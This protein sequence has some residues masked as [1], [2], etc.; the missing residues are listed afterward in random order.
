MLEEI[1][2]MRVNGDKEFDNLLNFEA[3]SKAC[4]FDIA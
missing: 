1:E 3:E 2:Y 4:N